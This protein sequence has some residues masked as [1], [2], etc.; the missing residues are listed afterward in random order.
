MESLSDSDRDWD[1]NLSKGLQ[2]LS[3]ALADMKKPPNR[4]F[5]NV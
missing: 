5:L 4:V 2:Y 1:L 3:E